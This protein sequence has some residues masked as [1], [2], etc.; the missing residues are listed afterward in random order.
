MHAVRIFRRQNFFPPGFERPGRRAAALGRDF[1][2]PA[3]MLARVPE[4]DAQPVKSA[5][6]IIEGAD[7]RE[8]LGQ[9][10]RRFGLPGFEP[11]SDLPGQPWLSLRAAA[12]H[13]RIDL[14]SDSSAPFL[15]SFTI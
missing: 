3:E 12:D 1:Q 14:S 6:F 5:D 9:R 4:S 15:E 13:D 10:W 8:L 2:R 7:M 11:A